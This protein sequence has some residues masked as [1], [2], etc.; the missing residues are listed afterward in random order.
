MVM[1]LLPLICVSLSCCTTFDGYYYDLE[2]ARS[3]KSFYENSDYLFTKDL[4]NTIIDFVVKEH[5]LYI[6]EIDSKDLTATTK[7]R[8]KHSSSFSIEENIYMF[9]QSNEHNWKSSSKLSLKEYSWCIV[10]KEFN[11]DYNDYPS[12]EFKYE[13]ESY[14]LCYML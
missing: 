11:D 14:C 8:V 9:E 7:Y 5:V 3:E 6:V 2:E 13:G 10:S 12:F 1:V 4:E